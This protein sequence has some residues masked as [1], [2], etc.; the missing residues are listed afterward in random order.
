MQRIWRDNGL[1]N[2]IF[3]IKAVKIDKESIVKYSSIWNIKREINVQRKLKHPHILR[4]LN[5]FEDP[6][7]VYLVLEYAPMGSL[8]EYIKKK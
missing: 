6:N 1:K 5:Y 2:G 8:F 7:K 3:V 4:L